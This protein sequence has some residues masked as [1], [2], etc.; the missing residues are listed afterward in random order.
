M[1]HAGGR[2][3]KF[4]SVEELKDKID[5]YFKITPIEEQMITGLAAY[6]DTSRETLCDYQDKDKFS[7][8][9]K[10]AKDRIEFAYEKRGLKVGNAFDIFRLKNMGWK[11][12]QEVEQNISGNLNINQSKIL[13]AIEQ[14]NRPEVIEQGVANEQPVQDNE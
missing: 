13:D 2:P 6:L 5:K 10:G 4:Q 8:T 1:V 11:D 7:D 14:S 3:L 12:K 9:I